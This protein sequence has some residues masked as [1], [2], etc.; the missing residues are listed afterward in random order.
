MEK[1]FLPW[2]RIYIFRNLILT[3]KYKID[4]CE[5]PPSSEWWTTIKFIPDEYPELKIHSRAGAFAAADIN[6][7]GIDDL[8]IYIPGIR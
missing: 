4:I 1:Y 8:V 3:Y 5:G 6:Q 7:D 2:T